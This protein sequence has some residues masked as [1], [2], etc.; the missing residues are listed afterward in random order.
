MLRVIDGSP[1]FVKTP[2]CRVG[3]VATAGTQG[4][5]SRLGGFPFRSYDFG[6]FFDESQIGAVFGDQDCSEMRSP[7]DTLL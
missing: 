5:A 1:A 6:A 7:R 2:A 3:A 4:D